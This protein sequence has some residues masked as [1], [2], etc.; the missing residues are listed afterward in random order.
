MLFRSARLCNG[1]GIVILLVVLLISVPVAAPRILGY[2]VYEVE[3][4][5]MEPEYPKGSL[6]YVREQSASEIQVGDVITFRLG[7]NTSY[8]MT[9]RV[10]DIEEGDFVTK[11]DANDSVD[12]E[13]VMAENLIGKTVH[14]IPKL[15]YFSAKMQQQEGII[16]L[17]LLFLTV[18]LLFWIGHTLEGSEGKQQEKEQ[19]EEGQEEGRRRKRTW[20]ITSCLGL[21]VGILVAC[22]A[23]WK[24]YG[25]LTEYHT[26][27][28][29][30]ETLTRT[31]VTEEE[32]VEEGEPWTA[33]HIDFEALKQINPELVGWLQFDELDID[34]PLVQTTDDAKYLTTTF[35]GE[36][37]ACGAIFLETA[38]NSDFSD[39]YTIIYGHNMK[40]LT[41]F[42]KL[43]Y[44]KTEENFYQNNRYFTIYTETGA[45]RYE[46]FSYE[47]VD[48]N[49][50]VY[51][52]GFTADDT[53]DTFLKG[54]LMASYEDTGVE[55]TATDQ[56]VTLSTC[57]TEG[58][59]FIVMG[60]KIKQIAY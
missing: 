10:A 23:S 59:R 19:K 60:K 24:I 37:N 42:G 55:M 51:T 46:I 41:M 2:Q 32:E 53:F 20:N 6:V 3:T 1:I 14:C 56:V 47:D 13:K 43:K 50:E 15:G 9:H 28:E 52:I 22:F 5:S 21:A 8:V 11:G 29:E 39:S 40:N 17:L 25:I 16:A 35:E 34:Y 36:K 48:Q 18:A 4:G 30:Y 12:P 26:G 54:R 31:Y 45:M 38:A 58:K 7:T 44:Y 49:S 57:S 33:V 27:E